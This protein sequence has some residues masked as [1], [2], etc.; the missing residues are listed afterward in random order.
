MNYNTIALD[1]D[2][3]RKKPWSTLIEFIS[4]LKEKNYSFNGYCIDLGCANGR[5]FLLFK[6]S[7]DRLIGLDNSMEFLLIAKENLKNSI[8]YSGESLKNFEFILADLKYIPFRS[9]SIDNIF[10]IA[11]FHHI[12]GRKNREKA[13]LDLSSIIKNSGFLLLT[14]WRRWQR[15]FKPYFIS[16]WIKRRFNLKYR[17]EQM[18]FDLYEFG[19]KLV[20]WKGSRGQKP[21]VRFYHLFSKRE[22]KKLLKNFKIR[23]F[24]LLGGSTKKDNF[25]ILN[26]KK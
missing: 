11:T 3:K 18:R 19:D 14:V 15:K 23:E 17:Q 12:K 2:L 8:R 9:Q 24:F 7:C 1:Y 22:I 5:H 20:P 21:Y 25:F 13:I 26:Q 10:S 4:Y 6:K 16:D